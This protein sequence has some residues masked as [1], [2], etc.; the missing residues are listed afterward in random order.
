MKTLIQ[1][2]RVTI[3]LILLLL[4][5]AS[6]NRAQGNLVNNSH[7]PTTSH[8]NLP[9]SSQY[10]QQQFDPPLDVGGYVSIAL[11]PLNDFLAISYYDATN[12]SLMVATPIA[13]HLGNCGTSN[14]WACVTLDSSG[15]VGRFS[16]IDLW[17]YSLDN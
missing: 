5:G 6:T 16:S 15:D 2:T 10:V 1:I 8:A 13:G 9:W 12:Q 4:V 3:L 17:G 7:Q 14:N 11:L